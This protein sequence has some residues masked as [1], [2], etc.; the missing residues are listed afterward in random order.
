MLGGG[1]QHRLRFGER[2]LG[3]LYLRRADVEFPLRTGALLDEL[4]GALGLDLG[5]IDL[6]LLLD[7]GGSGDGEVFLRGRDAGVGLGQLC[8][9]RIGVEL[10]QHL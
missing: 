1:L 4:P 9:Q 3:G 10:D 6:A 8:V 7:D 5:Q 2:R